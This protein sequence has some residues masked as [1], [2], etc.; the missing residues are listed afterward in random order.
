MNPELQRNFWLEYSFHRLLTLPAIL[1]MLFY[2]VY[3][4]SGE[5]GAGLN[6]ITKVCFVFFAIIWASRQLTDALLEEVR[7]HTWDWQRISAIPPWSLLWGKWLG[8]TLYSWYGAIICLVVMFFSSPLDFERQI[9]EILSLIF[10]AL[11]A[12]GISLLIC[13]QMFQRDRSMMRFHSHMAHFS[14]LFSGLFLVLFVWSSQTT[15]FDQWYNIPASDSAFVLVSLCVFCFWVVLG[16]YRLIATELQIRNGSL[17]WLG[18]IVFVLFYVGGYKQT[19]FSGLSFLVVMALSYLMLI[20]EGA[21]PS[22]LRQLNQAMQRHQWQNVFQHLPCWCVGLIPI[23]LY[24]VI[25]M[26]T[27]PDITLS[28]EMVDIRFF[29]V[30]LFIFFVRDVCVVGLMQARH[31]AKRKD[32]SIILYFLVMYALVPALLSALGMVSLLQVLIPSPTLASCMAA[33]VQVMILLFF[34]WPHIRQHEAAMPNDPT[35]H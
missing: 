28:A 12:Q 1:G 32:S 26:F 27:E 9:Y 14:G 2:V 25:L 34:L 29:Y 5:F 19:P 8:S 15:W 4:A 23:V 30:A 3:L 6:I 18:F 31:Q 11:F 24:A 33:V 7:Q 16:N 35:H 10:C 22:L 21:K 17:A 20:M 13:L